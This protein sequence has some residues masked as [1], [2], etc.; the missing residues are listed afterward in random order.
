MGEASLRAVVE[1][2]FR[3]VC[4]RR[5]QVDAQRPE[6]IH[7]TRVAFKRFRYSLEMLAPLLPGR[8]PVRVAAMRR[9]QALMGAVQDAAVS[10][11]WF[12]EF[13]ARGSGNADV[14]ERVRQRLLRRR[15][16]AIARYLAHADE[17]RDFWPL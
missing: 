2:R 16:R 10:S 9:Y 8:H 5:E 3:D 15:E 13:A 12:E 17:L 4:Q 1:A 6:T 7:E 11:E 14:V